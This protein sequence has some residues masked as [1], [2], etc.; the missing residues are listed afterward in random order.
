MIMKR[1]RSTLFEEYLLFFNI[2]SQIRLT[3]RPKNCAVLLLYCHL[4]LHISF[5]KGR[6]TVRVPIGKISKIDDIDIEFQN[7]TV[8]DFMKLL[9][10]QDKLKNRRITEINLWKLV[11]EIESTLPIPEVKIEDND[12]MMDPE[13]DLVDYFNP[14]DKIPKK[15]LLHIVIQPI[16]P[17]TDY[18][19]KKKPGVIEYDKISMD[20]SRVPT[21]LLYTNGLHWDYQE[22]P[23][24]ERILELFI[25]LPY[26]K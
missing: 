20:L 7:L 23:E 21:Q 6:V 12:I 1:L 3:I 17:I 19:N 8:D 4:S 22:S 24:L 16:F 13:K 15:R 18:L 2:I 10:R 26:K 9:L 14:N 25:Y 5:T 11:R